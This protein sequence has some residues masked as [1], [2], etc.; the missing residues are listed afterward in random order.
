MTD[1]ERELV[2][3]IGMSE[4]P[5]VWHWPFPLAATRGAGWLAGATFLVT[6]LAELK[7]GLLLALA[8]GVTAALALTGSLVVH[9][10]GHLIL[11]GKARGVTPRLV[12]LRGFGGVAICEG[13]YADARGA[14]RFAVGGPLGTLAAL[15]ATAGPAFLLGGPIAQVLRFVVL[16]NA[17]VLAANLLPLAPMDGYM[18]LRSWLWARAGERAVGERQAMHV[19]RALLALAGLAAVL[20]LWQDRYLGVM[21]AFC[22]AGFVAQHQL[23][24]R[25]IAAHRRAG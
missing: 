19:S 9:E 3:S 4:A 2:A 5:V 11:A 10:Y 7:H 12:L 8:G 21:V 13:S 23:A 6:M 20:V 16:L 18:L 22:I 24:A 17:L 1:S 14:A 15:V 25:Q